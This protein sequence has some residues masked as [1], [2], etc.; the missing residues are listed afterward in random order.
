MS[1]SRKLRA[2]I[3]A[4]GLALSTTLVAT[5]NSYAEPAPQIPVKTA[6]TTTIIA[7]TNNPAPAPVQLSPVDQRV[8]TLVDELLALGRAP[9]PDKNALNRKMD[10]IVAAVAA[11]G[12]PHQRAGSLPGSVFNFMIMAAGE[13][14]RPDI[15]ASLIK[16][17]ADVNNVDQGNLTATDYAMMNLTNAQRVTRTRIDSAI[18][19]LRHVENA[20]GDI[21]KSRMFQYVLVKS[22]KDLAVNI[23]G[24][25]AL[26]DAGLVTAAQYETTLNGPAHLQSKARLLTDL[27]VAW[28]RANG[29]VLVEYPDAAPGGPEPIKI[30]AGETLDILA[31]RFVN[32]M[33]AAD[34]PDALRKIAAL[35]NIALGANGVPA[36]ALTAGETILIPVPPENSLGY[37]TKPP[38]RT[39]AELA[40]HLQTIY[41]APN[42]TPDQILDET[43]RLNNMT[44]AEI[45]ALPDNATILV[46]FKNDSYTHVSP[47]TP[48]PWAGNNKGRSYVIIIESADYHGKQTYRVA[49]GTNYGLNPKADMSQFLNWDAMLIGYPGATG[50]YTPSD[51]QHMLLN[52]GD[53]PLRDRIIFS[54]SMGL[55]LARINPDSFR[56]DREAD[57]VSFEMLR[58]NLARLE[59]SR[60]IIFN[61]AGNEYP[62]AG[63]N[64]PPFMT[65]HGARTIN[66]GAVGRYP[67][68]QLGNNNP[69]ISPYSTLGGEFCAMLPTEYGDQMEGTSYTAPLLAGTYRQF[70]E[71]YGDDLTYEEI[72]AAGLM[73]AGRDLRDLD[74]VNGYY[75]RVPG[76][77]EAVPALFRTNGAGLGYSERCGP[78]VANIPLWNA[79]LVEMVQMKRAMIAAGQKPAE[80]KSQWLPAGTPRTVTTNGVTEYIYKVRVPESTTLGRLTFLVPQ[81]AGAHSAVTVKTPSGF[82]VTLPHSLYETISTHAFAYE[83][84]KAGD[85]IEIRTT[86]PLANTAA[87]IVR[88]HAPGNAIAALRDSLRKDGILPAPL[89]TFA[90]ANEVKAYPPP[91]PPIKPANDNKKTGGPGIDNAPVTPAPMPTI[92]PPQ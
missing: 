7:N 85:T 74:T 32:A 36:R 34:E 41:H 66:V 92:T 43:A 21:T 57:S 87:I 30:A 64:V 52:L 70:V 53:N 40:Q 82:T 83:D 4:I 72:M 29:A 48:P 3:A 10:D 35:N 8:V 71:W 68:P 18:A 38:G 49:M 2:R 27:S 79:K 13:M 50:S 51:A 23:V 76:G 81:H 6:A 89:R 62:G 15:V 44:R 14:N 22:H 86:A 33:K 42:A 55:T 9:A 73:T 60:P 67:V 11:G 61:A 45:D 88:G 58:L 46:N 26:R 59:K 24:M 91:S 75:K 65:S 5:F 28:L 84:V 77:V 31:R 56:N 16:A 47:L 1:G 39:M 78:G 20:G 90:G 63:R 25:A 12:N 69:T 19:I 17:G 37:V 80:M 54:H